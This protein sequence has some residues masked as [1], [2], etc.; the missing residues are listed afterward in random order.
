ME[1]EYMTKLRADMRNIAQ[2]IAD[3]AVRKHVQENIFF[4]HIFGGTFL[5]V[6][7]VM[8]AMIFLMK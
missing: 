2:E 6:Q 8:I 5:A 3:E 7:L 1:P 4:G